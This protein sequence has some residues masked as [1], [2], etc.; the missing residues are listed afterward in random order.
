M[1]F[2]QAVRE[3]RISEALAA[4]DPAQQAT[5]EVP[6]RDGKQLL[7]VVELDLEATVLNP[8]S[9]R[10]RSQLESDQRASI[11]N[12]E[13]FSEDAQ[14]TIR[15]ILRQSENYEDLKRNIE[16][17]GQQ[18]PGLVTASGLLVNA[19]RR[20]VAI[21]DLGRGYITAAVLPADASDGEISV[22]ELSLQMQEDFR[23]DYSYTNR[24]LFV[25][26]LIKEQ[27]KAA[28][29]V[30]RALNLASSS[31]PAAL[32]R[33]TAQVEQDLRVLSMIRQVQRRSDNKI[34]LTD[35]DEQE[36]ALEELD[37][38]YRELQASNPEHAEQLFELRLLGVLTMV[39]YRDIRLLEADAIERQ[40][41]PLMSEDEL[42]GDSVVALSQSGTREDGENDPAGLELLKDTALTVT[43]VVTPLVDLLASS[44][45]EDQVDLPLSDGSR[46]VA[47]DSLV[48]AVKD[49]LRS[50]AQERRNN[51]RVEDRLHAPTNMVLE[52]ERKLREAREAL[53]DV[54]EEP[55][56]NVERL[57]EALERA[58][59]QIRELARAAG[60]DPD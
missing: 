44:R 26:E 15:D 46:T 40:V 59:E 49:V 14:E 37:N 48:E 36:V 50:A 58:R 21:G 53:A 43:P 23:V 25:A 33:G 39:P 51:R 27:N 41:I 29:D 32:K 34:P 24:L 31:Q 9:H 30:A 17:D 10:I 5:T 56:F 18:T 28:R 22:L 54:V 3:Q 55:T 38:R 60:E 13:P 1:S 6:W 47:R 12:D 2:P 7:A 11:V 20:A 52:A 19:N 57:R 16:E 8:R 42:L 35:F 45:E 4:H